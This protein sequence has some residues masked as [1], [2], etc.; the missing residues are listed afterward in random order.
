[1]KKE[2]KNGNGTYLTVGQ[3]AKTLGV[4][5]QAVHQMI[6]DKRLSAIWMLERWAIFD[7]EIERVRKLRE[8]EAAA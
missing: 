4:S 1:M 8:S 6:N 7:A 5:R 3:A 2:N